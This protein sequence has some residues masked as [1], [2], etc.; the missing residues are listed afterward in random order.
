MVQ[1]LPLGQEMAAMSCGGGGQ[2]GLPV[3][4]KEFGNRTELKRRLY[5]LTIYL[6]FINDVM[7][8][9]EYHLFDDPTQAC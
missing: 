9:R 8:I 4:A 1:R 2:T 6:V 7:Y 5:L 3:T